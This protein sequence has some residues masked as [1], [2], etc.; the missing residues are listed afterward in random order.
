MY[1]IQFTF[2]KFFLKRHLKYLYGF[3]MFV[4]ERLVIFF[5][6]YTGISFDEN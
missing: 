2:R 3:F 4:H 6:N 5:H 1:Y